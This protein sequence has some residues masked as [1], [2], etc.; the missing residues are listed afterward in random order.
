MGV[1]YSPPIL[2]NIEIL[3]THSGEDFLAIF[4]VTWRIVIGNQR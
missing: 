2:K 1:I 4:D 3:E